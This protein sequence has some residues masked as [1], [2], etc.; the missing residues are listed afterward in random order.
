MDLVQKCRDDLFVGTNPT[1]ELITSG[2][3]SSEHNLMGASAGR[4]PGG[5]QLRR[6]CSVTVCRGVCLTR[7]EATQ[8]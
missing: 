2:C 5:E 6:Y 3:P 8:I 7:V 4:C 1:D